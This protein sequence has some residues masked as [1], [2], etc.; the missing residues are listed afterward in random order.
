MPNNSVVPHPMSFAIRLFL[1][2]L[3]ILFLSITLFAKRG[4]SPQTLGFFFMKM[5][6]CPLCNEKVKEFHKRSH[7]IPEWMY[8]NCYDEKHKTLEISS[9]KQ[10]VTKRQQGIYAQSI[11]RKCEKEKG[12]NSQARDLP[13]I[14]VASSVESIFAEEPEIKI[15]QFSVRITLSTNDSQPRTSCI[16]SKKKYTFSLSF[17]SG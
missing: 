3:F 7:L 10:K 8:T 17:F 16:S 13:L 9:L 5:L 14:W 15:M 1:G 11:C 12:N 6:T 4:C 2:S